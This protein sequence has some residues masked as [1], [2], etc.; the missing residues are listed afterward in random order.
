MNFHGAVSALNVQP[1]LLEFEISSHTSLPPWLDAV[2]VTSC[3]PSFTSPSNCFAH[4]GSADTYLQKCYHSQAGY[5]YQMLLSPEPVNVSFW[6]WKHDI[7]RRGVRWKSLDCVWRTDDEGRRIAD[8]LTWGR[9]GGQIPPLPAAVTHRGLTPLQGEALPTWDCASRVDLTSIPSAGV[10]EHI[11][12]IRDPESRTRDGSGDTRAET[13]GPRGV[14]HAQL[15]HSPASGLG[16]VS[17]PAAQPA[18]RPQAVSWSR[19]PKWNN[20]ITS[21]K[22][23]SF[24]WWCIWRIRTLAFSVDCN[25]A[26][27]FSCTKYSI[28]YIRSEDAKKN[29]TVFSSSPSSHPSGQSHLKLP[30]EINSGIY[31]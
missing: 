16:S 23:M 24:T 3:L 12:I 30:A 13:P 14:T 8:S 1:E 22:N 21:I 20:M 17:L 15:P 7:H 31:S 25:T 9:R 10:R 27:V 28:M 5:D 18:P 11:A 2:N 26:A 6:L 4:F 29:L 19:G